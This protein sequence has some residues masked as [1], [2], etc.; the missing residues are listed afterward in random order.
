MIRHTS[1]VSGMFA[2][3]D[4]QHTA[5]TAHTQHTHNTHTTH[6]QHTHNTHTT[7]TQTGRSFSG[8]IPF[9]NIRSKHVPSTQKINSF[10]HLFA[11]RA[12]LSLLGF[13][14]GYTGQDGGLAQNS[15]YVYTYCF[16]PPPGRFV[17]VV[18]YTF[19]VRQ[20]RCPLG[21][22]MCGLILFSRS[23]CSCCLFLSFFLMVMHQLM[24]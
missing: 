15:R 9:G 18:L 17:L 19:S 20:T 6:T 4:T 10:T 22:C 8:G 24:T 5:H 23:C 14:M 12:Q 2:I 16:V 21:A 1:L 11:V 7:H 13:A 3:T